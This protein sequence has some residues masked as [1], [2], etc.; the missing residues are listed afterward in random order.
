MDKIHLIQTQIDM[1]TIIDL[2]NK[3]KVFMFNY[4]NLNEPPP[5]DIETTISTI[6]NKFKLYRNNDD[7]YKITI[8]YNPQIQ[9]HIFSVVF[10]PNKIHRYINDIQSQPTDTLTNIELFATFDYVQDN[11]I[12]LEIP[13]KLID[14]KLKR[15]DVCI[16]IETTNPYKQYYTLYS[17]LQPSGRSRKKKSNYE[18]SLYHRSKSSETTIYDKTTEWNNHKDNINNPIDYNLTRFE[19]RSKH[20]PATPLIDIDFDVLIQSRYNDIVELFEIE[21]LKDDIL[22]HIISSINDT[23]TTL[24]KMITFLGKQSIRFLLKDYLI[25]NNLTFEQILY[26]ELN[27]S[28]QTFKSKLKKELFSISILD[29]NLSNLF[30]EVKDK[31]H[32]KAKRRMQSKHKT[33]KDY[34]LSS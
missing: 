13:Y 31:I 6:P 10:N 34:L 1:Q 22:S 4:T 9:S 16:D 20:N 3:N 24:N 15:D 33:Y 18:S 30:N 11:L 27:A 8:S 7:L 26:K 12:E 28:E 5:R 23:D 19:I 25:E 2:Q 29:D 14:M 32:S 21:I 17:M